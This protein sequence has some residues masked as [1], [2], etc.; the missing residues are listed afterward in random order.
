MSYEKMV[1]QTDVPTV[2]QLAQPTEGTNLHEYFAKL[3]E[4][5]ND[6]RLMASEA[7]VR[8]MGYTALTDLL[9]QSE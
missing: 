1:P 4:Y 3:Q 6:P 5:N 8:A 9:E 7:G 2:E